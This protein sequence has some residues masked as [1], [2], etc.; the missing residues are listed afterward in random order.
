MGNFIVWMSKKCILCNSVYCK[1][2][3]TWILVGH[4][5]NSSSQI[6]RL[7]SSVRVHQ[8]KFSVFKSKLDDIHTRLQILSNKSVSVPRNVGNREGT[9][10]K[11]IYFF[12]EWLIMSILQSIPM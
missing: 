4:L 7:D 12:Q 6:S 3:F 8:D 9:T 10:N 5:D 2:M 1:F 11:L